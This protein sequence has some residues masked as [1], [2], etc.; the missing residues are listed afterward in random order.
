[1]SLSIF[2]LYKPLIVSYTSNDL[3]PISDGAHP[4]GEKVQFPYLASKQK[5]A[6]SKKK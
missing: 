5:R 6:V 2:S 4:K 3:T 1:M